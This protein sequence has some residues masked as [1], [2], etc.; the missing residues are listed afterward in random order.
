MEKKKSILI[1]G[2][3][4]DLSLLPQKET[5]LYFGMR[6]FISF[7]PP[8]SE[9]PDFD[10]VITS[11]VYP[12]P[13]DYKT[14]EIMSVDEVFIRLEISGLVNFKRIKNERT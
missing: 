9:V 3:K 11:D 13:E 10:A 8:H 5:L 6:R 7:A 2:S 12:T 14:F 4:K 1:C